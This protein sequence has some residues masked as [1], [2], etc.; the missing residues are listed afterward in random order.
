MYPSD[1]LPVHFAFYH[2]KA[3]AYSHILIP[4]YLSYLRLSSTLV[5]PCVLKAGGRP[6]FCYASIIF[7]SY[8]FHQYFECSLYQYVNLLSFMLSQDLVGS[9][10]LLFTPSTICTCRIFTKLEQFWH[11]YLSPTIIIE[12]RK[13]DFTVYVRSLKHLCRFVPNMD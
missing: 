1:V 9:L 8:Q 13:E 12:F 7:I 2:K 3:E 11:L 5:L 10:E 6:N 4:S